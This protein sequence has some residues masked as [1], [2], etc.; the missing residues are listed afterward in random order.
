[1]GTSDNKMAT[2]TEAQKAGVDVTKAPEKADIERSEVEKTKVAVDL[3]GIETVEGAETAEISSDKISETEQK[4][5]DQYSGSGS[6]TQTQTIQGALRPLPS[7][8]VMRKEVKKALKKEMKDLHKKINRVINK[9]GNIEAHK[10][11]TLIAK[12]R[13]L[14]ELLSKMAHATSEFI[15]DLWMRFVKEK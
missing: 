1:M 8:E 9:G 5:K 7:P 6:G 11:N 2:E 10:L 13:S 15:K 12:L 4:A 14:R 3:Q